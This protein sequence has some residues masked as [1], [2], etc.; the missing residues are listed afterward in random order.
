MI[1][2]VVVYKKA[3]AA[4][5]KRALKALPN[6]Y[7]EVLVGFI[8]KSTAYICAFMHVA[9]RADPWQVMY[10]I[11][12][13]DKIWDD[14]QTVIPQL[15]RDPENRLVCL[16]SI[17]SHPGHDHTA[18]SYG[19]L[20]AMENSPDKILAVCAI[21]HPKEGKV[22]RRCKVAYWPTPRPIPVHYK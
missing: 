22:R 2:R 14:D 10:E 7:I 1:N 4:F 12:S 6:E 9:Q 20:L 11:E 13:D 3:E 16:G 15:M 21:S 19:D 18:F 5:R 17:H 8:H